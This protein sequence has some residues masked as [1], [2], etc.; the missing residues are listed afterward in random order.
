MSERTYP[1]KAWA[2][3]PA[4]K[5]VEVELTRAYSTWG[6]FQHWDVSDKGKAFSTELH[7]YPTKEEA[8][9]A[10]RKKIDE[11]RADIAKRIE[12]INKRAS[13]LDQAE[14]EA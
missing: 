6:Q 11:Q 14:R 7:L 12:R 4:F 13:A 1:Y 5:P 8:I 10:G 2:L 3:T 9:A